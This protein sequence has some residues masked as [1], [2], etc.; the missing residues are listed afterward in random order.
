MGWSGIYKESYSE[1]ALYTV[2]ILSH[3]NFM[4][5]PNYND[6]IDEVWPKRSLKVTYGH[7]RVYKLSF[8]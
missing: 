1:F 5:M 2:K 8:S 6:T 4:R 3:N 7:L